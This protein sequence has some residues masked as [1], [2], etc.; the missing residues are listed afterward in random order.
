MG[1]GSEP[2]FDSVPFEDDDER[3][4]PAFV[5]FVDQE[6]EEFNAKGDE[7]EATFGFSHYCTCAKDY[8]DGNVAETTACFGKLCEDAM[9]TCKQLKKERDALLILL[10]EK[11]DGETTPPTA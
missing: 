7:F 11:V 9:I 2:D 10:G 4:D 6:S 3:L 5:A 1:P 8:T